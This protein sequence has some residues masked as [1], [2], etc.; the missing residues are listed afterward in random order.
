M[1]THSRILRGLSAFGLA[2]CLGWAPGAGQTAAPAAPFDY[3]S[4]SWAV[5]GLADYARGTRLTPDNQLLLAGRE[6]VTIEIGE[7]PAALSRR[8][9]KTL[10]EGWIPV[11]LLSAEAGPVRYDFTIYASPLPDVPDSGG[12]YVGP[13]FGEDYL[14]WIMVR[15]TNQGAAPAKARVRIRHWEAAEPYAAV[16]ESPD[17]AAAPAKAKP[18]A[19]APKTLSVHE[20]AKALAPGEAQEDSVNTTFFPDAKRRTYPTADA[21]YWLERTEGFWKGKFDRLARFYVPEFKAVQAMKA[22]AACQILAMDKG[23]IH[24]GEGFYDVF[25]IRDGAYQVQALEEAG[26]LQD[27]RRA[28][29]AFLSHQRPDGRF[30]SQ[31]GQLDANGQAVWALWQFARISGDKAW[32]ESVFPRMVKA[33]DWAAA[34]RRGASPAPGGPFAGLLPPAPADGEYLWEG[35]NHIVGYDLWNLRAMI[36]AADAAERLGRSDEAR[37]LRKEASAYRAD[38]YAAWKRT[39]L[40]YFP[41]SWEKEG[42]HWGNTETLWPTPVLPVDDP[43]VD[44]ASRHLRTEHGGGYV[45]GVI[46]WIAPKLKPA[47]HPYMGAYTALN[48]LARGRD[49]LAVADFYAYLLHSTAANAFAEGI[50]YEERAAWGE[51]IPHATGASNFALLARHMLVH[52]GGESVDELHLLPAIPDWWIDNGE[53]I[54]IDRAPTHFGLLSLRAWGEAAGVQV[55]AALAGG[56]PPRAIVLHLPESRRLLA[57]V[58]EM[59]SDR[60][61]KGVRVAYRPAQSRRWDFPTVVAEYEKA[62]KK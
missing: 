58:K 46:R 23:E 27:A 31:P 59:G 40:P 18:K 21:K 39:G 11:V 45:E 29:G 28:M 5:V 57:P 10:R 9:I 44:A 55:Q 51:T 3:F 47:I 19:A 43:R 7:A 30:E 12:A 15:A 20:W 42:T 54:T 52:E 61:L 17:A 38:I 56:E 8:Q 22:A 25:Y 60:L 24:A 1:T 53:Q 32:L 36:C 33:A 41:P 2:G 62:A 13:A 37:R 16:A 34:A 4:N 48:D 35:K 50:H 6:R 14:T 49:E 26:L